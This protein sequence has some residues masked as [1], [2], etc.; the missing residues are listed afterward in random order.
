MFLFITEDKYF[1]FQQLRLLKD[2]VV[3]LRRLEDDISHT[4]M[5]K[6]DHT[7]FSIQYHELHSTN[8]TNY[9]QH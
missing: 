2:E 5:P 3:E 4:G 6:L 7:I 8:S 9:F 1:F